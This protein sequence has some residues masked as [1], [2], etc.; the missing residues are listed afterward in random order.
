MAAAAR[1]VARV[2]MPPLL[3]V[4]PDLSAGACRD[5]PDPDTFFPEAGD[6]V[7]A[8]RAKRICAGCPVRSAC[9]AYALATDEPHGVFGGLDP[10]ER[11]A[12][13]RK[14]AAAVALNPVGGAA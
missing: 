1:R 2:T 5:V 4:V 12:W 9:L 13:S 11:G 3:D 8:V 10:T 7:G 14:A 6:E